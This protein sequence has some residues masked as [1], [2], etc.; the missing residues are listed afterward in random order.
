MEDLTPTV[1]TVFLVNPASAGGSTGRRWPELAHR[2]ASLGL[3]GDALISEEPGHLTHLAEEA[4]RKSVS[5]TADQALELGVID[6]MAESLDDLLAKID[7]RTIP[8]SGG[9]SILHTKS[10]RPHTVEMSWSEKFL[11][12]ITDPNIAYILLSLGTIA[13]I[14]EFYHP[15]AIL[16]GLTGAISLVLAFTAFGVLQ[17]NWAGA[18]LIM[19]AI[20][21][22][23]ADLK[24]QGF[25]LSVGGTIA[26]V[27]GS[28]LLFKPQT[29]TLPSLPEI[30]VSPWLIAAM[31]SMW[32][33][34]FAFV[35]SATVRAH[36]AKLSS[37]VH[38]LLGA[39][40]VARTDLS[41]R[42]IVLVQSEEWSAEAI[43]E[44]IRKGEKVQVVEVLEGLYLRVI[45]ALL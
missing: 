29:P 19:L 15:G 1:S 14:A 11:H 4:V 30:S 33:G 40:G 34:F 13:L 44:P 42:G 37:G 3:V 45:K 27:L 26:F 28:I 21:L 8:T 5:I 38:T 2:A 39:T 32:V 22:F 16:P 6:L 7:G 23:L 9:N 41:P 12:T 10:A 17:P 35:L 18:A 24:V 25:A 31:T 36:R 20:I 43:D